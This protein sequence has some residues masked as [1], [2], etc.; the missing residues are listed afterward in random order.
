M[1]RACPTARIKETTRHISQRE[2]LILMQHYQFV[3]ERLPP[4]AQID[5]DTLAG[6]DQVAHSWLKNAALIDR[7]EQLHSR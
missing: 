5:A 2:I 3:T 7:R 1:A 6:F 4:A